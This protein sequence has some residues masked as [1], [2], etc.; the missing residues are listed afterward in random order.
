MRVNTDGRKRVL[1]VCIGNICRSPMAAALA[2]K[3]GSDVLV[4]S[5]AGLSPGVNN[6]PLTRSTLE[7]RNVDLGD[8]MPR[9]LKD[10][11]LENVDLVVNMSGRTLP[12]NGRPP[13]ETWDIRDP[14]GAPAPV[15]REVCSQLEMQV[16]RL[17]VRIRAGKI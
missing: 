14:I 15:Y 2:N 7:E 17:I 9:A 1:F 5:S 13:V 10:V 12:N 11:A 3:Y 16:M 6:S 8:H 4:A